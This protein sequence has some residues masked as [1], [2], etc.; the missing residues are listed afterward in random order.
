MFRKLIAGTAVAGALTFGAAGIAGAATTPGT[1]TGTNA[2]ARCAKLPGLETK[3]QAR[4]AK[5]NAWLPKAQ[6]REAK[7]NANGH[8]K[9][10]DAIAK[11]ITRVQNRESKINA[12]LA[13]AQAACGT[14]A[15]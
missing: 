3:V 4:E 6:A 5:V 12:R 2:A 9:V 8:P 15:G 14:S 13:K 7:A 10:A 1:P 11:R